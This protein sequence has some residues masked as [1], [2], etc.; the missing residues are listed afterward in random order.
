M[1]LR[2][3]QTWLWQVE[4]G[5]GLYVKCVPYRQRREL[6]MA[7]NW[8]LSS[9][10][11]M[12]FTVHLLMHLLYIYDSDSFDK[13]GVRDIGHKSDSMLPGGW[14]LGTGMTLAC[15]HSWRKIPVLRDVLHVQHTVSARYAEKSHK[16]Q[17]G[18]WSGPGDLKTLIL[19]S[20]ECT[21]YGSII[22]SSGR[23]SMS[24]DKW[25]TQFRSNTGKSIEIY[26]ERNC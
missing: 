10:S 1:L 13:V 26:C 16:N 24:D 5:Q 20:L 21:L 2:S 17:F 4:T 3:Q 15:F 23:T 18:I 8:L 11:N 7:P 22:R 14:T 19:A 25:A 9:F 12:R 6:W